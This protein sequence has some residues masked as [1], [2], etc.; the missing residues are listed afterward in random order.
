[1]KIAISSVYFDDFQ[2]KYG[3]PL[4]DYFVPFHRMQAKE[5]WRDKS[6]TGY[7]YNNKEKF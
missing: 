5:L 6:V 4:P 7:F 2:D 3:K 1:M